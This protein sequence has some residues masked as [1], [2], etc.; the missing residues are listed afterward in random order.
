[1]SIQFKISVK[2]LL[3][4]IAPAVAV[5][6]TNPSKECKS[7]FHVSLEATEEY[8]FANANGGRISVRNP[9]PYITTYC[10]EYKFVSGGSVTLRAADLLS[11]LQSFDK[12]EILTVEAVE[13]EKPPL[14]DDA[15]D[16]DKEFWE[17]LSGVNLRFSPASDPEQHQTLPILNLKI[18][19][20]P[21]DQKPASTV[22][23]SRPAMC[24]AMSRILFAGGFEERREKYL[25]WKLHSEKGYVRY[26]AGS[27]SRFADT[28][29]FG[30]G[31][32][33][34]KEPLDMLLP[35]EQSRVVL[36]VL[37]D[38]TANNVSLKH[39]GTKII[40][41]ADMLRLAVVGM[42]ANIQWVD[43]NK[44]IERTNLYKFTVP[45]SEW[46]MAVKGIIATNSEE[47][48]RVDPIH[49]VTFT[50]DTA[51][52]VVIL[53]SSRGTKKALRKMKMSDLWTNGPQ[54][55]ELQI[56]CVANFLAEVSTY[57]DK[58]GYVQLEL[59]GE[60]LPMIVRFYAADKVVHE[61]LLN[62]NP[63]IGAKEAFVMLIAKIN[64]NKG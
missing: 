5:A 1:M 31:I 7:A 39:Y 62:D 51:N 55:N 27:G 38:S 48:K 25:Y 41:E 11:V 46:D 22:I 49:A 34:A 45:L 3:E 20:Q 16:E 57:S 58:S 6:T 37:N 47:A 4:G 59:V 15:K 32:T 33:N 19:V 44:L 24:R 35:V 9:I 56:T 42:S 12:N 13:G 60:K 10:T 23:L 43:E 63:T 61:P 30:D 54:P 64:E 28:D 53:Q 21:P 36:K 26:I 14:P 52:K 8:L 40:I 17:M 50:F 29:Q 18:E 2:G